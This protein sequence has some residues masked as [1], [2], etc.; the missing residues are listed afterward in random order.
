MANGR[1]P[2]NPVDKEIGARIRAQRLALRMSQEALGD[3]IGLTFQQV[4]KYEKGTNRCS[5]SRLHQIAG[6]LKTTPAF[7]VSGQNSNDSGA[8]TEV[9]ALLDRADSLRLLR[10]FDTIKGTTRA[11]IVDLVESIANAT[12]A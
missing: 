12:G 8:M 3:A 11:S 5:G 7:L 6:A 4:Q 10:A 9:F 2:P 1:K